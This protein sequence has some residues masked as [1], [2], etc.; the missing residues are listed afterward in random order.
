MF[1]HFCHHYSRYSDEF[2]KLSLKDAINRKAIMIS[3]DDDCIEKAL[4]LIS[5]L[6]LNL[7]DKLPS[8]MHAAL[9]E[10]KRYYC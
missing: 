1:G 3:N 10:K 4:P 9:L 2:N 5:A 7:T 6:S 8:V